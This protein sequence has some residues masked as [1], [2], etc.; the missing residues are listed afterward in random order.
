MKRNLV[1]VKAILEAFEDDEDSIIAWQDIQEIKITIEGNCTMKDIQYHKELLIEAGFI[2]IANVPNYPP[3][4]VG[5]KITWQGHEYLE[6][7][8]NEIA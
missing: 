2:A 7:L 1:L 4:T 8:T 3:T 6:F 5:Y